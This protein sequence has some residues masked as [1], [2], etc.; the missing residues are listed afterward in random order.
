MPAPTAIQGAQAG[1]SVPQMLRRTFRSIPTQKFP[2]R[3]KDHPVGWSFCVVETTGTI[4]P[5]S[6]V[7][8][9]RLRFSKTACLCGFFAFFVSAYTNP[10]FKFSENSCT[11]LWAGDPLPIGFNTTPI[12][13]RRTRCTARGAP[14]SARPAQRRRLPSSSSAP[15][16]ARPCYPLCPCPM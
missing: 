7:F 2:P 1:P 5:V 12:C 11:V 15:W 16:K 14:S 3:K 10:K 6:A 8:V 13:S 4:A 9:R